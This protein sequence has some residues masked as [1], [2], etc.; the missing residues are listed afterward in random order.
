MFRNLDK[1]IMPLLQINRSEKK[2]T[3][4]FWIFLKLRENHKNCK[5]KHVSIDLFHSWKTML[6]INF[7]ACKN[8]FVSC[9]CSFQNHTP[10]CSCE[11]VRGYNGSNVLNMFKNPTIHTVRHTRKPSVGLIITI[12][13]VSLINN[14]IKIG[15]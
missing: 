8:D 3:K 1:V 10:H 6:R 4:L 11:I 9:S 13:F 5:T 14:V 7:V 15:F 2:H 12:R